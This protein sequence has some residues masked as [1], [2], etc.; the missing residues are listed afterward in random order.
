VIRFFTEDR[1]AAM[2]AA[3]AGEKAKYSWDRLAETVEEL[4]RG[5]RAG[6]SE[7]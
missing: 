4:A 2:A 1:A 5:P 7:R 3:V 6:A